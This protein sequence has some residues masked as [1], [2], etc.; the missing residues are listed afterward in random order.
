MP[1]RIAM[2]AARAFLI[3]LLALA[4]LA[5]RAPVAEHSDVARADVSEHDHHGHSH[6]NQ[7]E[8]AAA[9]SGHDHDRFHGGDHSHDTPT[10]AVMSTLGFMAPEDPGPGML[11]AR[12]SSRSNLP[13]DRPPRRA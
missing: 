12:V 4:V 8:S 9:P 2:A 5:F 13:G 7:D 11:D 3:C 10:A 6:D 1:T